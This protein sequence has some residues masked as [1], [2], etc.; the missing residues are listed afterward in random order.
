MTYS[1]NEP[2]L[3]IKVIVPLWIFNAI[4]TA[5]TRQMNGACFGDCYRLFYLRTF[6]FNLLTTTQIK[7]R[8]R[9][10]TFSLR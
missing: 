9:L 1:F 6:P 4:N 7:K 8:P 2:L 10:E 5:H 3:K